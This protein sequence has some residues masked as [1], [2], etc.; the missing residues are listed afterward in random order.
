MFTKGIR[1]I[2][3][4]S[5]TA[6]FSAAAFADQSLDI[7]GGTK[8]LNGSPVIAMNW[9]SGDA[10]AVWC[11]TDAKNRNF[12]RIWA[13]ELTRNQN[14]SYAVGKPFLVSPDTG[15]HQRPAVAYHPIGNTYAIVWDTAPRFDIAALRGG[16]IQQ[17]LNVGPTKIMFREYAPAGATPAFSGL[18]ELRTA[19]DD[20]KS[21]VS[22][23]FLAPVEHIDFGHMQKFLLGFYRLPGVSA[24]DED[25]DFC[26][27]AYELY[28][29]IHYLVCRSIYSS[30][31][32]RLIAGMHFVFGVDLVDIIATIIFVQIIFS[33]EEPTDVSAYTKKVILM[34]YD[35]GTWKETQS[36]RPLGVISG[37]GIKKQVELGTTK[38]YI[39]DFN[40]ALTDIG[41]KRYVT[42]DNAND[43]GEGVIT[44]FKMNLG[45]KKDFGSPRKKGDEKTDCLRLV[46]IKERAQIHEISP[47]G[48][49]NVYAFYRTTDGW[50]RIRNLTT[51]GKPTGKE[52]K[53]F[54]ASKKFAGLGNVAAYNGDFLIP[55]VETKN[56]KNSKI[57][58][59]VFNSK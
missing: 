40:A 26:E 19:F 33:A 23:P 30:P 59:Q 31:I 11:Q 21:S 53:A 10:L 45:G 44:A 24:T 39:R 9:V 6:L 42:L 48:R 1:T 37:V 13:A 25:D 4:V 17:M 57:K 5:L 58:L 34:Q 20:G 12:G 18:G 29:L 41:G 36:G 47:P 49:S 51:K 15:S 8:K 38:Q 3:M 27:G 14:G 22:M 32:G 43:D 56:K 55:W 7:S 28:Q 52:Q 54:K 50:F 35:V 46:K 2:L 16:N